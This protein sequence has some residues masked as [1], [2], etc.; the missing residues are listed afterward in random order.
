MLSASDIIKLFTS[1]AGILAHNHVLIDINEGNL[2]PYVEADLKKQLAAQSF[3]QI[4]HR[5]S[6]INMLPKV[7]DKL[8]NIY[9][10]GVTR[11]V[12]D[13][14]ETDAALLDWYVK[15]Y[16]ANEQ[17]HESNM[18]YN[19]TKTSLVYPYVYRGAPKLRVYPS[20]NFV[21][22]S[23]DTVDPTRPTHVIIYYGKI[24]K[25]DIYYA[26]SDT[27]FVIVDSEENIRIDLMAQYGNAEG[28][29][30]VGRLPFVYVNASKQ[31]LCP[32]PDTDILRMI[33]LLPIMCSDLNLASMFQCFSILYTIDVTNAD[34]KFAPNA[35]WPLQSDSTTDKKPE[36]GS[37]KPTV[38]YDQVLNLI[39]SQLSIWLSTKGIRA[40]SI[41]QL[42][43]D[44]F[45]SGISKMIDEMDT[46]E[47]R[48]KQTTVYQNAEAELWDLTMN[49]MHPY[50]S[51]TG[52]IDNTARWTP[53]AT[54][55][56]KFAVQLPAQSRGVA[57]RDLRD[58]YAAGFISRKRAL[59]KLNPEMTDTEIDI[60]MAEIDAERFV[61]DSDNL[62]QDKPDTDN[63]G[64]TEDVDAGTA[65]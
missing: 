13:G 56:T 38:D 16:K 51:E 23:N 45:A 36:I 1:K 63:G 21:V 12:M 9:Q 26:W 62:Q 28:M 42:T 54:V 15:S 35:V 8:T 40:G 64:D 48:Q 59:A 30:P 32:K 25:K 60:L 50:W 22:Y 17:L 10:T 65:S 34:L 11:Q 33:K 37:I 4:M 58:E 53:T 49:Y 61:N 39:Q 47:A 20:D 46:F 19:L 57:V 52:A 41:G 24:D 18:Y 31:H 7:M 2:S 3:E 29:N 27:E 43:Q 14:T 6:P 55:A 44:N 5:L